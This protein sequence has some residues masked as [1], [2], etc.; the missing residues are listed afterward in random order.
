METFSALLAICAGN[1]PVP[2]EFPTQRPV[3]RSFDVYFDLRTNKRLS[4]QNRGWW[5]ETLSPPLW[6]HRNVSVALNI[7]CKALDGTKQFWTLWWTSLRGSASCN[8][9]GM[10]TVWLTICGTEMALV[11]CYQELIVTKPINKRA[12]LSSVLGT[13]I[14]LCLGTCSDRIGQPT[15][16]VW[17]GIIITTPRNVLE[18][19]CGHLGMFMIHAWLWFHTEACIYLVGG[20]KVE[21]GFVS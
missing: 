20:P 9:F 14:K 4:K 10:N 11:N 5:F 3:T 8:V 12:V 19:T 17:F 7:E 15:L 1:S 2:G 21:T 16:L 13:V 18:N 6:R